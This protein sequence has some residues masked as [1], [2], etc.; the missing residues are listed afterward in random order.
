MI[1]LVFIPFGHICAVV[2]DMWNS[3]G[4]INKAKNA[5][6]CPRLTLNAPQMP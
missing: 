6:L 3:P 4:R 2:T 1:E 5:V